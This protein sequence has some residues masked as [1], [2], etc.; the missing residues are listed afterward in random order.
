V[1]R[2]C[3]GYVR[4]HEAALDLAQEVFLAAHRRIGDLREGTRFGAWLFMVA[5]NRC[6]D[7]VRSRERRKVERVP[8]DGLAARGPDP[9][10]RLIERYDEEH[11]LAILEDA[12][13]VDER[14]A[15]GLR[16]FERM[17]VDMITDVLGL[18]TASG[19][20]GLLQTAR[21]KLRAV[22]AEQDDG[23]GGART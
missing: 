20:R 9:E 5:R 21:R 17:P 8:V 23:Q 16:C 12:L 4:E 6:L 18:T 7:E 14:T 22:L 2:W 19:A 15:I 11:L 3:Y 13:D 10:R 1:Y